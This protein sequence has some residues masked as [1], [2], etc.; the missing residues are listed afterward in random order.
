[1]I[2]LTPRQRVVLC[3][4]AGFLEAKGYSPS[5]SEIA[6]A[7]GS[8]SKCQVDYDLAALEGASCIKR[9]R[10]RRRAIEVLRPVAIPRSPEG[11]PLYFVEVCQ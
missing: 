3:F 8:K 10:N 5:F 9:L 6:R 2:G 4:V 7:S 11:A 1:M